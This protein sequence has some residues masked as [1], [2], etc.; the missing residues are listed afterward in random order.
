MK[1]KESE[2]RSQYKLDPQIWQFQ[3]NWLYIDD[4]YNISQSDL[5]K[6]LIK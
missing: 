6:N 2:K 3:R 4:S 5:K 1:D